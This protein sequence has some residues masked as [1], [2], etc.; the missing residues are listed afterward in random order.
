MIGT[1]NIKKERNELHQSQKIVQLLDWYKLKLGY[2]IVMLFNTENNYILIYCRPVFSSQLC[3]YTQYFFQDTF[4]LHNV[5]TK[6]DF[7]QR[8]MLI[9]FLHERFFFFYKN[10]FFFTV[11]HEKDMIQ[12]NNLNFHTLTFQFNIVG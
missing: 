11:L 3:K 2:C 6:Q 4:L 8:L 1:K 5:K 10:A 7:R 9:Q 12:K